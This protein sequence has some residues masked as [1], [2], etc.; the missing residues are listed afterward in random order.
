MSTITHLSAND[1]AYVFLYRFKDVEQKAIYALQKEFY[2]F[3]KGKRYILSL[4][5]KLC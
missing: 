4:Y 5:Y 3:S 2:T 1:Q